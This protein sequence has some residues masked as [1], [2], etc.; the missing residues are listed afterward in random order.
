M[1]DRVR[2][3]ERVD[4]QPVLRE[5][6]AFEVQAQQAPHQRVRAV[7]ADQ[8]ARAD[9]ATARPSASFSRAWTKLAVVDEA[10]ELDAE[11]HLDA[12]WSASFARSS[13]SSSGW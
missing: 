9:L 13:C 6:L 11:P 4:D 2:N 10:V 5:G 3:V 8:E 1:V 12:G 7:A